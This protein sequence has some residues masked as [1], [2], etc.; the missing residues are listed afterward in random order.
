MVAGQFR[1][2]AAFA[3]WTAGAVHANALRAGPFQA[4]TRRASQRRLQDT[5][6]RPMALK[7]PKGFVTSQSA[8]L[9]LS[10][11]RQVQQLAGMWQAAPS[12]PGS[13][14]RQQGPARSNQLRNHLPSQTLR[15]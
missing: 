8:Q 11:S 15:H 13:G 12:E 14:C 2:N 4:G 1:E 9:E 10:R 5:E 3:M 6:G 7:R